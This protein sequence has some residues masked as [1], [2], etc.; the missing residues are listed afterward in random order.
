MPLTVSIAPATTRHATA[1]HS[2]FAK[3]KPTIATPQSAAPKTTARPWRCTRADQPLV[4]VT[5]I[6]PADGA[7]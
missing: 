4:S 7:A 3:P 5:T 1:S 2:A 6:E